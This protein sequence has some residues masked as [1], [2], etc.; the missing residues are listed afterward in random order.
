MSSAIDARDAYTRG[1]SRRVGRYARGIGRQLQLAHD[2][3]ERL[4]LT[5]LLHDI[6]KIGVP[7]RVLLKAGRLSDD[8]FDLIKQHPE[9]GYRIL[10]PI[11]ELSFALP[12]VLHHHE[13]I[14]GQG[15]PHGLGGEEIPFSARILAVAD[16]YDAMTSSRTY[17]TAMSTEKAQG[18]LAD[19]AGQQW[20]RPIVA[21]FLRVLKDA[22]AAQAAQD[23]TKDSLGD[24]TDFF[25]LAGDTS[26][27]DDEHE[28]PPVRWQTDS[29]IV[30]RAKQQ[31]T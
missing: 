28:E 3:C 23:V 17:R 11:A 6:G 27:L 26:V 31:R 19:G 30:P 20:D 10:E 24:S 13:R 18:V 2:D 14:D 4:Y 1:H 29:M 9:I 15:Y 25:V 22:A 5:G 7:D 16:A 21:A 8:E 12:G